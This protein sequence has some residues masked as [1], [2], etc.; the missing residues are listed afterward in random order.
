MITQHTHRSFT[1]D[2]KSI[3]GY[4]HYFMESTNKIKDAVCN[5]TK[6]SRTCN[7]YRISKITKYVIYNITMYGLWLGSLFQD[8]VYLKFS[9]P[10][11]NSVIFPNG[12][13]LLSSTTFFKKKS[14]T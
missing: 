9:G 5:V 6:C 3:C 4:F 13:K 12:D 10:E 1:Y 8:S 14:N 7:Q 2:Q 11:I